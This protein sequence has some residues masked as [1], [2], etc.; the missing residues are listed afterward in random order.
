MTREKAAQVD[1]AR[2][3]VLGERAASCS[4]ARTNCAGTVI[5]TG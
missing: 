1:S 5:K 3:K 4:G 2:A